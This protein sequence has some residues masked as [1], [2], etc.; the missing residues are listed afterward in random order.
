MLNGF[1]FETAPLSDYEL[2][3]VVPLLVRFFRRR[4]GENKAVTN[5]YLCRKMQAKGYVVSEARIRKAISHIR[6][7]NLVPCLI[8]SS[9]GYF[10]VHPDSDRLKEYIDS[11]KGREMAIRAVREALEEQAV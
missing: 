10:R 6:L 9:K 8:A 5:H 3:K 2:N 4:Y 11:L 7:C 1:E